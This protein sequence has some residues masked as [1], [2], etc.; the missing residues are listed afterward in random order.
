MSLSIV[1]ALI[2]IG[3]IFLVIELFL[4]PGVSLAGIAGTLLFGG[5]IYYAYTNIGGMTAHIVFLVSIVLL[6]GGIWL[7]L[8]MKILEKMSLTA[9]ID[10]KVDPLNGIKLKVGDTGTTISRLAPM[11]KVKIN[12]SVIEAKTN[13]EFIDED[14]NIKVL[15]V[16]STN[17][18]V[19]KEE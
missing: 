6:V 9:E 8:K 4:I 5:A 1:I 19:E 2:L 10:G 18:L 14:V 13:G 15:E 12:G 16:Y 3:I 17:V 11:G 7:F